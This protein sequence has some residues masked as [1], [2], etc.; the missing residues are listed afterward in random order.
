MTDNIDTAKRRKRRA[1][2]LKNVVEI[3]LVKKWWFNS[4]SLPLLRLQLN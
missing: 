3:V 2:V 4:L 1:E